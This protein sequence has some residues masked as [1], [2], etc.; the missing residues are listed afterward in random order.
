MALL[1]GSLGLYSTRTVSFS[2]SPCDPAHA[3]ANRQGGEQVVGWWGHEVGQR[4]GS[5]V[6]IPTRDRGTGA[7]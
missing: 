7:V 5:C 6:G 2:H 3:C 4:D 1:T